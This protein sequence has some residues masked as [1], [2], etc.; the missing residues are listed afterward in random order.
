LVEKEKVGDS[1][2]AGT[3]RACSNEG[4]GENEY[5]HDKFMIIAEIIFVPW[6]DSYI[7]DINRERNYYNCEGFEHITT[8]CRKQRNQRRIG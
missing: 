8:Y 3:S 4:S 6:Y 7:M 1:S 5:S 2:T